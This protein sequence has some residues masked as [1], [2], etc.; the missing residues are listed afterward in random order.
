MSSSQAIVATV[1]G[2]NYIQRLCKHWSHRLAVEFSE[3]SA[4]VDFGDGVRAEF[5]V[6]PDHLRIEIFGGEDLLEKFEGVVSS[7]LERFA[8]KE[9]LTIAWARTESAL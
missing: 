2:S 3:S 6:P 9:S 1:H 4:R 8:S 7:H 5:S